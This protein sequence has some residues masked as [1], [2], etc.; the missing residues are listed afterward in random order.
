MHEQHQ[1]GLD[2]QTWSTCHIAWQFTDATHTTAVFW[3]DAGERKGAY[4]MAQ[5]E[6]TFRPRRKNTG[7]EASYELAQDEQTVEALNAFVSQLL[8]G[9]WEELLE[10]GFYWWNRSFHHVVTA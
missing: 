3:A 8:Q 6:K 4:K 2:M 5:G 10:E 1:G 7:Y 9:G